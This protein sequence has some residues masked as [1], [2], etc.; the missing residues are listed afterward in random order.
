M[1]LSNSDKHPCFL[2][3]ENQKWTLSLKAMGASEDTT[4]GTR[5]GQLPSALGSPWKSGSW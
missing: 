2:Y 5:H 3:P 1:I 4:D